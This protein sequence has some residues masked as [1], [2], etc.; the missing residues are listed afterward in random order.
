M[1]RVIFL[2]LDGLSWNMIDELL[3]VNQLKNFR[4]IINT[5]VSTVMRAEGF[6]SSPKIFC[7]IFTGK[8]VEKHGIR[9]F[10]SKEEDL[11]T[12]QIWDLL[13]EKGF[14]IGVYRPLSVW[15]AKKFDGFCVPNPL[16]L[17]KSTYPQSLNFIGEL[18]IKARSEKYSISFMIKLFWKLVRFG[19][20]LTQLLKII[21]RS[22][23]LAFK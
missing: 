23:I 2:A 17:E 3:A 19:L 1:E 5:G 13:H 20:P 8:K 10:Y 22:M 4:K 14:R 21:K 6:L 15:S 16:L 7:S 12:D 11:K 9:D 18:D